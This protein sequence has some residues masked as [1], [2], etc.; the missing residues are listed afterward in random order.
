MSCLVQL[1]KTCWINANKIV[2]IEIEEVIDPAANNEVGPA[3]K[4]YRLAVQLEGDSSKCYS[5]CLA[6]TIESAVE[7]SKY[8]IGKMI[9]LS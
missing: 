7:M 3:R 9:K 1:S 4:Q 6:D 8:L 5:G 2:K